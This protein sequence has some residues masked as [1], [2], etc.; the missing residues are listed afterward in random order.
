MNKLIDICK[1]NGANILTGLGVVGVASTAIMAA[2]AT[3]KALDILAEK[4][5]YKKEHYYGE[6]LTRFEK[7]LAV[8]P[9]YL[10]AI[11]MGT[12]TTACILGANHINHIKQANL[13][14]AYTCL[15]ASF[16]EY[17]NKVKDIYGEEG[18][19]RVV[20]ELEK[21]RYISEQYGDPSEKRLFY[22][23]FS[24]R[25][26]EMSIFEILKATYD[27][28]RM[29]NILGEMSLNELYEFFNL[30]PVKIGEGLGWNASKEFACGHYAW[31]DIRWEPI[32]TPDNL[33]AFALVF[34]IDPNDDFREW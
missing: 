29:Y 9:P 15:D 31:I 13:L 24:K 26:F 8:I 10:P 2:K 12:A 18:E 19:K 7:V 34:A 25:Y 4:E 22:D 16:K 3:P 27:A 20:E 11:L 14:A 5:E 33:E 23:E 21:E 30:S 1:D 32:E 6:S 28:N 17:R